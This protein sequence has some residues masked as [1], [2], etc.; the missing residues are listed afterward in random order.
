MEVE[1]DA[2]AA[3]PLPP[4]PPRKRALGGG[5]DAAGRLTSPLGGAAAGGGRGRGLTANSMPAS[6]SHPAGSPGSPAVDPIRPPPPPELGP[7]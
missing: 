6:R 7:P 3:R 1:L 5:R 4:L 2:A